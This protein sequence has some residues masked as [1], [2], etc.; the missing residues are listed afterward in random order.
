[1][2]VHIN[3][4]DQIYVYVLCPRHKQT[5]LF[6]FVESERNCFGGRQRL[7]VLSFILILHTFS[8]SI[9]TRTYKIER[10]GDEMKGEK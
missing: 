5:R 3:T 9:Y 2:C 1:M 4:I 8:R 10:Y 6:S 7:I